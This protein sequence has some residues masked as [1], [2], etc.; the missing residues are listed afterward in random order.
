[1]SSRRDFLKQGFLG[2]AV[3]VMSGNKLFGAVSVLDTIEI[4]QN[5]LFPYAKELQSNSREYLSLILNHNHISD[6]NKNS[7]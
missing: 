2:T 3:I 1:M 6:K 7:Y 5:D 4:V